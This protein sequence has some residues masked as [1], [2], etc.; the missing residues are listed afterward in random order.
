MIIKILVLFVILAGCSTEDRV[1]TSG[2]M[3]QED[4]VAA[5]GHEISYRA[6]YKVIEVDENTRC[7]VTLDHRSKPTALAC[8]WGR[9]SAESGN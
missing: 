9:A 1:K 7:V 6:S 2:E 3:R 5:V 8:D 4:R